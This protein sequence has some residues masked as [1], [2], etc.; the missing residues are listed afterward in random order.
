MSC[1][2]NTT[3]KYHVLCKE[4]KEGLSGKAIKEKLITKKPQQFFGCLATEEYL[5]AQAK[6]SMVP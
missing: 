1:H 3:P 5:F 6:H 2:Q 4:M